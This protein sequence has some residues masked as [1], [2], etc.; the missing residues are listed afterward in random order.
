MGRESRHTEVVMSNRDAVHHN[1]GVE[2]AA[3][4]QFICSEI[5]E[6]RGAHV[7]IE[8]VTERLIRPSAD[9]VPEVIEMTSMGLKLDFA[10]EGELEVVELDDEDFEEIEDT[11]FGEQPVKRPP[12]VPSPLPTMH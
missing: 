6:G 10:P 8:P 2:P 4:R 3:L 5:L 1:F 12:P 7:E 11:S 9:D